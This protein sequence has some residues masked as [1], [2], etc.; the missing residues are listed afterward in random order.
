MI[1]PNPHLSVGIPTYNRRAEFIECLNSIISQARRFGVRIYVSD[2][3]SDYDVLAVIEE[4]RRSYPLI[5]YH[6]NVTNLGL[7]ANVRQVLSM[8]ESEYVWVFSD[9]D[10]M[11]EGALNLIVPLCQSGKYT[12]ILPDR[13]LYSRNMS[14]P[15]AAYSHINGVTRPTVYDDPVQLFVKYGYWHYT[16]VGSLLVKLADWRQVDKAKYT[17]CLWF[18]HTC[19]LAETMLGRRALVLPDSLVRIRCD[20]N[21]Y[22]KSWWLVWLKYFPMALAALPDAYPLNCRR[23]VLSDFTRIS[24]QSPFLLMLNGRAIGALNWTNRQS[25]FVPLNR[26]RAVSWVIVGY[27]A[28]VVPSGLIV[29]LKHWRVSRQHHARLA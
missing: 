10:T 14:Q 15:I 8:V 5:V 19:I 7:D 26:I 28:L 23:Q 18:E 16:F 29:W 3:A 6:R 21:T 24:Q 12:L 22:R 20:N 4:Y 2:N 13:E 1:I 11:A 27:L 9:D 25:I 17:S